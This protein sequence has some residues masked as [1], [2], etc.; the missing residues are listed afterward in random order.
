VRVLSCALALVAALIFATSATLQQNA[1]RAT[2]LHRLENETHRSDRKHWLP[3]LGELSRLARNPLWMLGWV[4]NITGFLTH[5]VALHLGSI[6]VVQAILVVQVMF[7]VGT[8]AVLRRQRPKPREFYGAAAVCTGVILV[9]ILR[10]EVPQVVPPREHVI[11]VVIGAVFSIATVLVIARGLPRT[12]LR[13]ALVAI[14]AGICFSITAIMVVTVTNDLATYGPIG[15]VD[16]PA[17]TMALSAIVGSLL[18]QDSFASGS[19]PVALTAMTVTD[20]MASGVAGLVLFDAGMPGP[21]TIA[22]LAGAAVLIAVGVGVVANS[23][24]LTP[25]PAAAA[26]RAP[27]DT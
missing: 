5:A 22:G 10:G 6:T 15:I 4:L 14:G 9:I 27:A 13:S 2:A 23:A 8:A 25:G 21:T 3:V 19:L 20:P 17:A 26:V 11:R 16:W 1:A 24:S 7:A 18:V 12:N